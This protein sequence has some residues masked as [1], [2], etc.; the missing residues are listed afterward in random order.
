VDSP[1]EVLPAAKAIATRIA[2]LPPLAV[3]HTKRALNR[4]TQ[5]RAG[6][7]FEYSLALEQITLMSTDIIEAVESFKEKRAPVYKGQ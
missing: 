3:Q 2:S 6:E 1:E 4:A 7:V 5:Q